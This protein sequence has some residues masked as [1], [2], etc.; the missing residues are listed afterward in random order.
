MYLFQDKTSP[1]KS[2]SRKLRVN[3]SQLT[4]GTCLDCRFG[5]HLEGRPPL[6]S[7]GLRKGQQTMPEGELVQHQVPDDEAVR[8][9]EGEQLQRGHRP[10]G[11]G[12]VPERHRRHEAEPPVQLQVQ[13]RHEEGEE[14]PQDLLELVS[15]L[16]W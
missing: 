7:A 5:F 9:G 14:L 11:A 6:S 13:E 2:A 15:E 3:A 16:A 1:I 8:K 4:H 12:R 10:R